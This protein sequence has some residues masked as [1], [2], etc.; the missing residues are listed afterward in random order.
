FLRLLPVITQHQ[1]FRPSIQSTDR[2]AFVGSRTFRNLTWHIY[3]YHSSSGCNSLASVIGV[4]LCVT[5]E[6]NHG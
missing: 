6:K 1:K 3:Q 5:Q 4:E 2:T